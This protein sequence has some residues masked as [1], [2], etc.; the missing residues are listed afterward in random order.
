MLGALAAAGAAGSVAGCAPSAMGDDME[1]PSGRTINIG[2]ISPALGPYAKIGADLTKGFT[3]YLEDH[4]YL[5]GRHR[6]NLIKAE[7]GATG[8]TAVAAATKLLKEDVLAIAGVA[9]PASLGAIAG[10]VQDAKVPLLSSGAAPSGLTS[11]L[12][13]W[14]VGQVEGEAGRSLGG[15]AY[16]E[17][18]STYILQD[19]TQSAKDEADEFRA[20]FQDEGGNVL[21][22]YVGRSD[23]GYRLNVAAASGADTIFAACSGADALAMLQNYRAADLTVKLIGP[24]ALT[25]TVDLTKLDELPAR[26]YTS[27]YYAA[28]LDNEQNRRFVS[29]Y[30]KVHGVQPSAYA[31]AAYDSASVLDKALRIVEGELA[32]VALN[33]AMS[34]LG[35]IDSP[36]GS[37][38]FNIRRS[39]QQKWYLRRLRLDG[40]V[41]ANVLDTDLVVL[42]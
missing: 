14:R 3:L 33:L 29:S 1:R 27:M 6:V 25:E 15:Y 12:Y 17:G 18:Q 5:L 36:R 13:V 24:G 42:S 39:P 23:Y 35:Q 41:P 22:E 31:M 28:D 20:A 16:A 8:K 37:W 19:G 38:T 4:D 34:L 32:P 7:E 30:H 40:Q 11:A 21:G 2:L 26:V 10:V 9:S